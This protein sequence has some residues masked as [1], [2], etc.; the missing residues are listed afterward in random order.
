MKFRWPIAALFLAFCPPIY[1]QDVPL[2]LKGNVVVVQVDHVVVVKEDR[3]VVKSLPFTISAPKAAGADYTWTFPA[4]VTA[5]DNEDTLEVTKAPKGELTISLKILSVADN[6]LVRQKGKLVFNVGDVVPPPIPTP[7]PNPV[8]PLPD[9]APIS[10]KGLHVLVV[11]D[12]GD[13]GKAKLTNKQADELYGKA[14]NDY[15]TAKCAKGAD[16]KSQVRIWPSTVPLANAPEVWRRAMGR[17][18]TA[19][20]WIIVSD[21]EH[22]FEGP[23]PDGGILDL[24]KKYGG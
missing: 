1:A 20:P 15:V 5:N 2:T 4:S 3:T 10:D 12:Y 18:R 9:V 13:N 6:K 14:F 17:S 22:G 8:D 23:L 19:S 11:F 7:T 24:V 21:G 16:G